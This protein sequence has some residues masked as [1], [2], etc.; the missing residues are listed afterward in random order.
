MKIIK[1]F[2]YFILKTLV[3]IILKV[4]FK[5][6]V[7]INS[8]E[9]T[10]DPII[11][12]CNHNNLFVDAM[13]MIGYIKRPIN[14]IMAKISITYYPIIGFFW[15]FLYVLL[16]NRPQDFQKEGEGKIIKIEK[17]KIVGKSTKFKTLKP[18][19]KL[20]INTTEE[21]EITKIL[22]DTQIQIKEKNTSTTYNPGKPYKI[23]PKPLQAKNLYKNI[24]NSFER[25][26]I[27]CLFPEGSSHDKPFMLPFKAGVANFIYITKKE[28]NINIKMIPCSINYL[29][30]H[31]FRSNIFVN[32][33][34]AVIYEFDSERFEDKGYKREKIGEM[35]TDIRQ[36]IESTKISAPTYA[37]LRD[38]Y[39]VKE[40]ICDG[41]LLGDQ[42]GFFF[43]LKLCHFYNRNLGNEKLRKVMRNIGF[44]RKTLKGNLIKIGDI[45]EDT[46][47]RTKKLRVIFFE[48]FAYFFLLLPALVLIHPMR[49]ILN[50]LAEK[51]RVKNQNSS[52]AYTRILS[53]DLIATEK[54]FKSMIILPI[55]LHGYT[56]I[57]FLVY[58]YYYS[59]LLLGFV[60]SILFFFIFSNYLIF[61]NYFYDKLKKLTFLIFQKIR[62]KVVSDQSI[63]NYLED[64]IN[65]KY[66]FTLKFLKIYFDCENKK[67]SDITTIIP[68]E[69]LSD[70]Y[71][72]KQKELI[73]NSLRSY[74]K[75]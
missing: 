65:M 61:S 2:L 64:L 47:L 12:P 4:Y 37:E 6:I 45:R 48:F 34:K 35:L 44:F 69:K 52:Y 57:F 20:K 14:F 18:Q 72:L 23:L 3:R 38:L 27:L 39:F 74:Y 7:V 31:K 5:K 25:K 42:D 13:I 56:F 19:D 41:S 24:L 58:Y 62:M 17:T 30:A 26:E 36:R 51:E 28:R 15:K 70:E 1:K 10:N 32:F 16:V 55:L 8:E 50:K 73:L 68:K 53:T 67:N 9:I 54:I 33:G 22:S 46:V 59:N 49:I 71:F 66:H 40:L 63:Y 21:Y 75:K 29:G 60:F 43:Y 11:L